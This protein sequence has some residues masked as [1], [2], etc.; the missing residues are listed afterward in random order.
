[1]STWIMSEINATVIKESVSKRARIL[2]AALQ[3]NTAETVF[4]V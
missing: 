4:G 3:H 2:G 1:M